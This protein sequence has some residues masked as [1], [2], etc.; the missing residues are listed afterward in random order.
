MSIASKKMS[1]RCLLSVFGTLTALA[2]NMSIAFATD[3]N[4]K[5]DSWDTNEIQEKLAK[6]KPEV[7]EVVNDPLFTG[8]V[9]YDAYALG[10]VLTNEGIEPC[11]V[12]QQI[13]FKAKDGYTVT[14]PLS[15]FLPGAE[16]NTASYL[17]TN[18]HGATKDKPWRS[19]NE[20]REVVTPAPFALIWS[21]DHNTVSKG[22]PF[23]HM[24]IE[25]S[26]AKA[27]V[28]PRSPG[29]EA[30][31]VVQT[32]AKLFT[33][34]CSACHSINL[35]G[36]IVGPELNVP[37]NVTEYWSGEMLRKM[38]KEPISVHAGSRM[39]GFSYLPEGELEAL[40]AYV[41]FMKTKKVCQTGKDCAELLA[42]R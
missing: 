1:V 3:C 38:I 22:R 35:S 20:G 31:E 5:V 33:S 16:S 39:P 23:P 32:G 8:N 6:L 34:N 11:G 28:D 42:K 24:I 7:V 27:S 21:G 14:R 40:L 15:D 29:V 13:T 37:M 4:S 9:K 36:G 25:I 10:A 26:F 30:S 12:E 17:A 41:E 18:E 2:V 19:L